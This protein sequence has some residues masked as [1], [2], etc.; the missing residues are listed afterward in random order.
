LRVERELERRE[1]EI[2]G[3]MPARRMMQEGVGRLGGLRGNDITK[4][5]TEI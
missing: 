3:K 1:G 4:R 5:E 2:E